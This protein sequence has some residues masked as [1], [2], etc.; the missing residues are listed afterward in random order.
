MS[1]LTKN[2]ISN[3]LYILQDLASREYTDIES[4]DFEVIFS[5]KDGCDHSCDASIVDIAKNAA[6]V[7]EMLSAPQNNWISV[8]GAELKKKTLY[9]VLKSNGDVVE[10]RFNDYRS[11]G[12][13]RDYWQDLHHNDFLM[14]DTKFIEIIK[15]TPPE[16]K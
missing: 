7:I 15:P 1:D 14:D 5:D 6:E 13:P 11:F 4:D 12:G 2:K 3:V 16:G 10:A 9:H 8:D